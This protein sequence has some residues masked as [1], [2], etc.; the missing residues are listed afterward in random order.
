MKLFRGSEVDAMQTLYTLN[1]F[2]YF[3]DAF[4]LMHFDSVFKTLSRT[5]G[6]L[7]KK[8]ELFTLK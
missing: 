4:D 7:N 8:S 3:L 6:I 5:I 2:A 1:I